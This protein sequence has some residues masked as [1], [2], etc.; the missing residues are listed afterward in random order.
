MYKAAVEAKGL[1]SYGRSQLGFLVS[2]SSADVM[3]TNADS[4]MLVDHD[5]EGINMNIGTEPEAELD[6]RDRKIVFSKNTSWTS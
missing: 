3:T 2:P 4:A 6:V 1:N 5:W